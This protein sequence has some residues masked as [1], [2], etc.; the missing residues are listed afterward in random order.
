MNRRHILLYDANKLFV[1]LTERASVLFPHRSSRILKETFSKNW[2][3]Y[4]SLQVAVQ[5]SW[6]SIDE[7]NDAIRDQLTILSP[8][9]AVFLRADFVVS[10]LT[11]E[12]QANII[13]RIKPWRP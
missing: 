5:I 11:W 4:F 13:Q 3:L 10:S 7:W 8:Q 1:A 12:E 9:G 6:N 2:L